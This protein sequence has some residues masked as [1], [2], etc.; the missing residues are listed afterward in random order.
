MPTGHESIAGPVADRRFVSALFADIVGYTAFTEGRDPDEVRD[1]LTVYFDRSRAIIER[2]GGVVEKFIGDAIF[3]V[4]G[5]ESIREDDAERAV[6]AGLE[7]VSMVSAL[8]DEQRHDGLRLRVGVM[9]GS[10]TVGPGGNETGMI[11][12]DLVNTSARVQSIAEPGTVFVGRATQEVTARSIVYES[13]GTVELKGKSEPVEVWRAVRPAGRVGGDVNMRELPFGGRDREMRLLKDWLDATSAEQRSRLVSVT[14]E[15]GIGKSRLAKEFMNHVD[16]FADA[17]YWHQGRSPSYG[18][19]IPMWSLVEMVRQRAGILEDEE[20]TRARTRLRTMLAEFVED[21]D[22]RNWIEG[23]VAGLLG[24]ADLPTGSRSELLSALRSLFQ[25]IARRGTT[26]LVFEDL[27]WADDAVVEFITDLVDRS[28]RAPILVI[29]LARPELLDRH[30]G[31]GSQQRASI[32]VALAPLH[33]DDMRA[34]VGEYLDGV[35]PDVVDRIVE[36]AS[37]FPLYAAEIIRML[38]NSGSLVA[39]GEGYVWQGDSVALAIPDS[40]QAVIGARLDRLDPTHRAVLQ[41]ASVLGLT[42][43]PA[44]LRGVGRSTDAD[45][46]EALRQLVRLDVLEV[47]DELRSPERGQYRFIQGLIQ[48]LAYGALNRSERRA[49]HI[50]AAEYFGRDDDPE[51]AGVVAKH[52]VGAYESSPDGP[53]RNELV[54]RAIDSLI[55][56]A[57]RSA[58]LHAGVVAMDLYDHAIELSERSDT[59]IAVWCVEA[60]ANARDEGF[61]DRGLAYLDR[62]AA[63]YAGVDDRRGAQLVAV[64]R[65]EILNSYF[66]SP[67]ALAVIE[68]VYHALAEIDDELSLRIAAEAVRS[69]SLVMR[70]DEAVAVADR[71]LPVAEALELTSITVDLLISRATALGFG[72]RPVEAIAGLAG[73]IEI[74]DREGLLAP[75]ARATNNLMATM[76]SIHPRASRNWQHRM[77]DYVQ[78]FGRQEWIVRLEM[79]IATTALSNGS[80]DEIADLVASVDERQLSGTQLAFVEWVEWYGALSDV[81]AGA[82]GW[83]RMM[84]LAAGRLLATD[85]EQLLIGLADGLAVLHGVRGD[86]PEAHRQ[87]LVAGAREPAG[88]FQALHAAVRLRDTALVDQVEQVLST[89]MPGPIR[90]SL[91]ALAEMARL[92]LAGDVAVCAERFVSLMPRLEE[93]AL[94]QDVATAKAIFVSLVGDDHQAARQAGEELLAWIERGGLWGLYTMWADLLPEPST[95]RASRVG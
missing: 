61:K 27:H 87:G 55:G 71:A 72:S 63:L 11:V 60:A 92:G 1:L 23:W 3:G 64:A 83:E 95:A 38:T 25:H 42:F 69:Y 78:R 75:A 15:A 30:P 20:P 7:L 54:Q 93:V 89:T 5:T 56:A 91:L 46:D 8:G 86:W 62:A 80:L 34:V 81:I 77:A 53:E 88:L 37:G 90:T 74:A 84:E 13:R 57:R 21:T 48:E 85:D 9:S 28:T 66:E 32:K 73:A 51:L 19:G 18:D 33:H 70:A 2:F 43:Q 76:R 22:D 94:E 35:D 14:G 24:V 47:V 49:R 39:D 45:V 40:L 10:T 6:R 12:G 50:A 52:Y 26:V 41:D 59:R 31:F 82:D 68:P 67:A 44:A 16:G 58:A 65:S 36:R 29:A 4:W 79:D 17:V